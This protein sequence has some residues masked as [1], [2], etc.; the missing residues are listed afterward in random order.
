MIARMRLKAV[1]MAVIWQFRLRRRRMQRLWLM[2]EH[3]AR[4]RLGHARHPNSD[5]SE[6]DEDPRMPWE[7]DFG[8]W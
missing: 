6:T 1:V 4:P 2:L 5:S 3:R 8:P 7:V